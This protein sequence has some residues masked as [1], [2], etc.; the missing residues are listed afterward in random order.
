MVI[1]NGHIKQRQ[2]AI[3]HFPMADTDS[4]IWCVIGALVLL[5]LLDV[6][7]L[8]ATAQGK[9]RRISRYVSEHKVR[10][11]ERASNP[12][13][14]KKATDSLLLLA[15]SGNPR[16]LK[17]YLERLPRLEAKKAPNRLLLTEYAIL[18]YQPEKAKSLLE[19]FSKKEQV[20]DTLYYRYL[21]SR[22]RQLER[23]MAG[24]ADLTFLKETSRDTL[25]RQKRD[26]RELTAPFGI[27][28]QESYMPSSGQLQWRVI[29]NG[30]GGSTFGILYR[31]GDGSWDEGNIQEVTLRGLS[32]QGEVGYPF[33]MPDGVTLYFSYRG[34][35][36]LGGWDIYLSR[37]VAR[38]HSLLVPQQLPIPINSPYDDYGYVQDE[39]SGSALFLSNRFCS[40]DSI[41]LVAIQPRIVKGF[42]KEQV[43]AQ[44][45]SLDT[46]V[47]SSKNLA[48]RSFLHQG[49]ETYTK[50]AIQQ[51]T[52]DREKKQKKE[53]PLHLQGRVITKESELHHPKAKQLFTRLNQLQEKEERLLERLQYFRDSHKKRDQ[54]EAKTILQLEE[55]LFLL[56]V[57]IKSIRNELIIVEQKKQ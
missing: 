43:L 35:E 31:L 2:E 24:M 21:Q 36:T 7:P 4:F 26:W 45:A 13:S 38:D 42:S 20:Q 37:Y 17:E 9:S 18:T 8:S 27:L 49:T 56:T 11:S 22:T 52:R 15:R 51:Y 19:S 25:S 40:K 29:P 10:N 44:Y 1:I 23:M 12:S 33:L 3:L 28:T 14:V 39:K 47:T 53:R 57:E 16:P 48:F 41:W 5:F 6:H 34:P 50:E 54:E 30:R 46:L 32:D 55:T